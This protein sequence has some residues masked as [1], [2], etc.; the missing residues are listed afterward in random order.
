[1]FPPPLQRRGGNLD[2]PTLRIQPKSAIIIPNECVY[3]LAW[4]AVL[5]GQR[6]L[7]SVSPAYESN[8]CRPQYRAIRINRNLKYERRQRVFEM[9]GLEVTLPISGQI[10]VRK[11]Q[12]DPGFSICRDGMRRRDH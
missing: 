8:P 2:Q 11:T 4:E 12:P 5:D 9:K 10:T 6:T 1:M 7:G 3:R